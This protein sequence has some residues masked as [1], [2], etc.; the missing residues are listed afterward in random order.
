MTVDERGERAG[1]A[2]AGAFEDALSAARG[3]PDSV[4][5]WDTL[6]ALAGDEQRPEEAAALYREVL[7]GSPSAEVA[8]LLAERAVG[9]HEEW[10]PE[11]SEQLADVLERV[12]WIDPTV[13]DWAFSRLTMIHTVAQRWDA[14]LGLYDKLIPTQEDES[15][16]ETLLEEA[17]QTAKDFAGDAGRAT[18]YLRQLLA[19]RPDDAQLASTLERLLEREE[20]FGDLAELLA[21]R[22]EGEQDSSATR[23]RLARLYLDRLSREDEGVAV[24]EPLLVAEGQAGE[25]A[26]TLLQ[27]LVADT[28]RPAAARRRA[29]G[30]MR[31]RFA[32]EDRITDVVGTL[33][34]ALEL[35]DG[36]ERLSLHR[37]A[38]AH[39]LAGGDA[40][41][42]FDHL[43]AILTLRPLDEEALEALRATGRELNAPARVAA[44]LVA[45]ADACP[46][47]EA[48]ASL[49]M[50][51][52]RLLGEAGQGES[53]RELLGQVAGSDQ[54]RSST[55]A[56]AAAILAELHAADGQSA[57]Q[58][59][60]LARRAELLKD[61]SARRRAL[62][63]LARAAEAAGDSATALGAWGQR[64][65][66][67]PGDMEAL[68]ARLALLDA[69]G[70]HAA[71]VQ[72]LR[73]RLSLPMPAHQRRQ[74]L[75]RIARLQADALDAP[76]DA[77]L[78][79]SEVAE[80][81]GEDI[82]V[83]DARAHLLES[84]ARFEELAALLERRA[85][86]EAAHACGVLTRLG[87]IRAA[88]L[89]DAAG[90]VEAYGQALA[91]DPHHV[92]ALEGLRELLEVEQV[93]RQALELLAVTA[94]RSGDLAG[95]VALLDRRVALAEEPIERASIA[96]EAARHLEGSLQDPAAALAAV[97]QALQHTPGDRSLDAHLDRLR[98]STG[99]DTSVAEAL[100]AAAAN[101]DDGARRAELYGRAA[102]LYEALEDN[103][104]AF[105]AFCAVLEAD[106]T[107][108]DAAA[109]V[110]TLAAVVGEDAVALETLGAAVDRP[111]IAQ[112][113]L[114]I[115]RRLGGR[116]LF[117]ALMAS[118]EHRSQSLDELHEAA[119]L[120]GES[121]DDAALAGR[122]LGVLYDRAS[123]LL[124]G[125]R[126]ASGEL[127][128]ADAAAASVEALVAFARAAGDAQAALAQ[129]ED[130]ARLPLDTERVRTWLGQAAGIAGDELQDPRR[131][132]DLYRELL[133]LG[134]DDP[135]ALG[136][137]ADLY[138]AA[139]RLPELLGLRQRQLAATADVAERLELRMRIA[140][141]LSEIEREGGRVASL[142]RNLEEVPGHAASI[143]Q[144]EAVLTSESRGEELVSI[145]SEQAARV[146]REQAPELW[147]RVARLC[148][149]PLGQPE[150]ALDAWRRVAEL[151]PSTEALDALA[152]LH[153]SRGEHAGAARWL[154]RRLSAAE[155]EEWL[156][157]A[158]R[159]GIAHLASGEGERAAEV[160]EQARVAQPADQRARDLLLEHYRASAG[161][162]PLARV[163][164]DAALRSRGEEA[165]GYAREAAA[166]FQDELSDPAAALDVL[167]HAVALDP[168]DRALSLRYAESLQAAHRGAEARAVLE[169]V[170]VSFGRRRSAERA[171][172]HARL[173][174]LLHAAGETEAALE[175][176]EQATKM[177]QASPRLLAK[178]GRMAREAGQLE[179]AEKAYRA[180]LVAARRRLEGTPVE[181]GVGEVLFELSAL[182][183]QG[184][185]AAQ[186]KELRAS[187]LE[188]A[189][190]DDDEAERLAQAAL[191]HGEDALAL[192]AYGRRTEASESG[193]SRARA[194][195]GEAEVLDTRLG[196]AEEALT[197][198]LA[199]VEQDPRRIP[200][201]DA[202]RSLARRLDASKRYVTV[203]ERLVEGCRREEDAHLLC[204]LL[205]QQ[206]RAVEEDL[207]DMAQALTL[208]R[209]ADETREARAL[210][211]SALARAARAQ[212]ERAEERKALS[213][214]VDEE[215]ASESE[216][217][218]ALYR[219][220][221]LSLGETERRDEGVDILRLAFSRSP[222]P[223]RAGEIL[224]AAASLDPDHDGLMSFFEEVAR[225]SGDDRLMLDF[226]ERRAARADATL[227][228]LQEA[229]ER[230]Q[231]LDAQERAERLMQRAVSLADAAGGAATDA[232]WALFGLVERRQAAGD[233][234]GAVSHI[235]RLMEDADS[236]ERRELRM[237]LASMARADGRDLPLAAE[238]YGELLS[239]EP[240]DAEIWRPLLAVLVELG[241][242]EE[243]GSLAARLVDDLLDPAERNEARMAHARFELRD[244]DGEATA[245]ELLKAVLEEDP[246]HAEAG[247]LLAGL[248]EKSGYDDQ[249]VE[250]YQRQL[251]V[252][253]DR[254]DL[255]EIP[256][257]SLKLGALLET[258]RRDD[259]IEIY[260][261]ALDWVP[262]DRRIV[263]AL[264]THVEADA[265]PR[266]LLDL[267]ERLLATTEGAQGTRLA[268]ELCD[269][270]EALE[271]D[272]GMQRVLMLGYHANPDDASL[273]DR[274][275]GRLRERED[276]AMLAEF[277]AGEAQRLAGDEQA[278]LELLL[279]AARLKRESLDDA[280]GAVA[281]LREAH[282]RTAS[283]RVLLELLAAREALG[284]VDTAHAEATAALQA[285]TV[286]ATDRPEV[287]RILARLSAALGDRGAALEALEQGFALDAAGTAGPLV[288][289]L[290]ATRRA[291]E[292]AGD[293][294]A[295]RVAVMRLVE[296][297]AAAG[298]RAQSRDV[299]ADWA[300]SRGD[301]VGALN[302]LEAMDLLAERWPDV[303]ESTR[304][305]V[306]LSQ[307]EEQVEVALLLADA[308]EA[309]GTPGSAREGL[310][311]AHRAQPGEARLSERLAALYEAIGARRELAALL[312]EEAAAAEDEQGFELYRRAGRLL[313]DEG[314][315]EA[316]LGPLSAALG[317]MPDDHHTQVTLADAYIA[318]QRI[319]EAGQLL[320]HAIGEHTRRR[321]PE[322]AQLQHR[323]A[324][325]A[326]AVEDRDLE[327]QWLAAA[328]D[329]DKNNADVA[330]E[331]AL[332]A[333]ELEDWD[334]ALLA[335][336]AVTLC[337]TEGVMSRALAFLHQARIAHTRGESRR[338]LLWA[339][340]ARSEDPD[341][342]EAEA[343]LAEL[344][345]G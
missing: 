200:L 298:D 143:D 194:L 14:L 208:Y 79:W 96:M 215:D 334:K 328:L 9:F 279:Q 255:S 158:L 319:A 68:D 66:L 50:D 129:L 20:R 59:A 179:R 106:P 234:R 181:V 99:D 314:D 115:A 241:R 98:Q 242:G 185:D 40:S 332:L 294:D 67:D 291:A 92:G 124:R 43:A 150:R 244:E 73:L 82:E 155:P 196:R 5:A 12:L 210:V 233:L 218:Q 49:R 274:L 142:R 125:K 227:V 198:I 282:E 6:E 231:G 146:P 278:S 39:L 186:A 77:L 268:L 345:E 91:L 138:E 197:K 76:S 303:V 310:E 323:M 266:D 289:M 262:T 230:A 239:E 259:A 2:P 236:L 101:A 256:A 32:A 199:A 104:K 16:R 296:V 33:D 240:T 37:Q 71:L 180:L 35:A 64:L 46:D 78:T 267:R 290:M 275:E 102:S 151:A 178:L 157:I 336:R 335:L 19:L 222:K 316:A 342:E 24:L 211:L 288:A 52:A 117:D 88:K 109:R 85:G 302:R 271:D 57:E 246:E 202:A 249:L 127:A 261:A 193:P 166:L 55:A 170:V 89:G 213:E 62:G 1:V 287:L 111:Q 100:A 97:A 280:E 174:E 94:R 191:G 264:I 165:L 329:A 344:G 31:T 341:L 87:G 135:G 311:Q 144:L 283:T 260:R 340:K 58:L 28:T 317:L 90:A 325:L 313:V 118:A 132:A 130:A 72:A 56:D 23:L 281:V 123:R 308:A 139:G 156:E 134:D 63:D 321:S 247:A 254:E 105:A 80:S 95:L 176:L 160:L 34:A 74:D 338:A 164:S 29:L 108:L 188:A 320:E 195:A 237:S 41:E 248:Y 171:E 113:R 203:M 253:R 133:A 140:K 225:G 223:R 38:A 3:A 209:A 232:R 126:E 61:P 70:E 172:V 75:V 216:R 295:A 161:I 224:T 189:A 36:D 219:L 204:L 83:A 168:E 147:A 47:A 205:V 272:E 112:A 300:L 284:D 326:H 69:G 212:G 15:R 30:L 333:M 337:R 250:L 286:S 44:A 251:D 149:A 183:A 245:A 192:E 322:L 177:P 305:L 318:T 27:A 217:V 226:L 306:V 119:G 297:L 25:E 128:P 93:S 136:A 184:G 84:E 258:V 173:A 201:H 45:A 86:A 81:F 324:R 299:L 301:D 131:A 243:L 257:L 162:L 53:A 7:G 148:E 8:E 304:R 42:A 145:L 252:A 312:I 169:G 273:R 331:Y 315:A 22:L 17:A 65:A 121:L 4:E 54:V 327:F 110:A 277:L 206:G 163:L 137:L 120:A 270:W 103:A 235:N 122:A 214:L 114:E 238:T 285:D 343:F 11:E 263:E 152:R 269:A 107:R 167:E 265:G 26:V 154:E 292:E 13:Y 229:V 10:F 221:E 159:L 182:S 307:G 228:Q 48:A 18:G 153:E 190:S 330:G 60:A 141:L 51:A 116:A 220:A 339:R 21:T 187:A 309:A 293:M 276:W 175:A 207:G